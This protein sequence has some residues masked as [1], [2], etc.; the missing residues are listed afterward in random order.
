MEKGGRKIIVYSHGFGV[1][2]DDRG[3]LTDIAAALPDWEHRLF[4]YNEVAAN[5]D[6]TAAPLHRQAELLKA[7][8]QAAQ[9]TQPD[10]IAIVAHSQGC[11]TVALA[12][13]RGIDRTILLTP[14]LAISFERMS[15]MFGSRP[16]TEIDRH[17]VSK[18]ARADFTTTFVHSDYW[19]EL[20]AI[21]PTALYTQLAQQG[22]LDVI[23]ATGDHVL[24]QQAWPAHAAG[25]VHLLPGDH[26]FTG[27]DR[28]GLLDTIKEIMTHG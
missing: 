12:G 6:L 28:A 4:D 23:F 5:G 2:Q 7:Q 20:P 27:P 19:D 25:Q 26:S 17:G 9:A 18:L 1:R 8:M 14:Q 3:L 10:E 15:Q 11:L 21:N 22:R 16:G 13:L 24:R